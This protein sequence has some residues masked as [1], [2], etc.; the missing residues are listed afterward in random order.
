MERWKRYCTELYGS[1]DQ[2]TAVDAAQSDLVQQEPD[3]LQ[4]EVECAIA[5]LKDGKSPGKDGISA[6]LLK[7]LSSNGVRQLLHICNSIWKTG[8]WPVDWT[9][10]MF[11][12]LHKKGS[13]RDCNNYRTLALIPHVSKIL[14]YII[15]HRLKHFL[16]R[17]IPE[18]Q[19][20]F[21]L[22]KGTREQILNV[23]QII[24]KSR[25]FNSPVLLCFID[26]TKAFDCVQWDK[27]WEVLSEMGTPRHL[28]DL[29]RNLYMNNRSFVKLDTECSNVFCVRK[30]V[31]QGCILSPLLFN[32]Y[33]EHIIRKALEDWD[34]GFAVGGSV[35]VICDM[36]MTRFSLLLLL[37]T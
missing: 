18:E 4:S 37:L 30:G 26:Y 28:I 2:P 15:N 25:E 6:E 22:G 35:S 12:P 36:L 13:T 1:P 10:S 33:G 17:Q 32:I 29:V 5:S 16:Q 7:S 14:L 19:A 20:G 27:L 8:I 24:E 11:V 21:V 23:R 31:R 9:E 3:I 34:K